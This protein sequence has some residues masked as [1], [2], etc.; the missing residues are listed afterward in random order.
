MFDKYGVENDIKKIFKK[1]VWLKSGGHIIIE[2]AEGLTVVDVNTGR[3]QSGK[4]QE[5]TIYTLN[6]EAAI[7]IVR[8]IRLRNLV[9]IIV[10]DFIDIKN[11]QLPGCPV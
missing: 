7:E 11:R 10:I 5:E 1:K 9:G 4:D 6:V 2:E 3:Y 8:Q